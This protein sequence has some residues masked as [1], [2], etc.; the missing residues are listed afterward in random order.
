MAM[1]PKTKIKI[2]LVAFAVGAVVLVYLM[3]TQVLSILEPRYS[4]YALFPDAGGVFTNQEVTYRGVTVG[5][6]GTMEVV[7]DGVRIE[8]LIDEDIDVPAEGV[9]A[10]VMFKSAVGEQFVDLLPSRDGG[11]YLEHG[12]VIPLDQTSI[13]VST[14]ELLTTVEAV[15]RGVPPKALKGAVDALGLGL[16]GR[17]EDIASILESTAELAELFA[18]RS[19]EV[20]GILQE[21]TKLG[22]AFLASKE[23][24][25]AAVRDLIDVADSLSRSTPNL[26]RLLRGTSVTADELVALIDEQ[27]PELNQVL[28][29]LGEVNELQ[30]GHKEDVRRLLKFLPPALGGVART[31]ESETGMIRFGL[32]QDST[33]HACSYGTERRRPE[34]RGD[35]KIPKHASCGEEEQSATA[36][37]FAGTIE[38]AGLFGATSAAP[39]FG[40]T[41]P[42]LP[43][44]MADW[45]WT[46]FYLNVM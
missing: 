15:L 10:R 33:N 16:T 21:G 32:V 31:F 8:L 5:N 44:R 27:R 29:Q 23:E 4:V 38:P 1:S 41:A 12:D 34:D 43:P 11:P 46:L 42:A 9:E 2:N 7:E 36:T 40:P 14:Q 19:P 6:V 13:P 35:R 28:R 39:R 22:D 17:G 3:A 24:F 18:E 37:S 45:S 20:I 25:A 30:A 26:D